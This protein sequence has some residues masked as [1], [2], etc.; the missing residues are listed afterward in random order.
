[1]AVWE[2]CTESRLSPLSV[3]ATICG[4]TVSPLVVTLSLWPSPLVSMPPPSRPMSWYGLAPS[5]SSTLPVMTRLAASAFASII[6][7][8][9]CVAPTS[10]TAAIAATFEAGA[11]T[12]R[13]VPSS[14]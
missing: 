1:M 13:T 5:V 11:S 8:I 4:G 7:G 14:A 9:S 6:S 3:T 12:R 2:N 10:S